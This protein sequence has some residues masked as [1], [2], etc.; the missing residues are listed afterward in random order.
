MYCTNCGEQ[1]E[2]SSF[3]P[4]C[5]TRS[6]PAASVHRAVNGVVQAAP[7]VLVSRPPSLPVFAYP[8]VQSELPANRIRWNL[9]RFRVFEQNVTCP[10]C[11][12]CGPM[13]IVKERTPFYANCFVLFILAITLVGLVVVLLLAILGKLS[14]THLV[15]CPQCGVQFEIRG[16]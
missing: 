8:A 5:G 1:I 2:V 6:V 7:P 15:E 10:H 13:G 4:H 14:R 3:C 16:R 11:G 9:A 12:Y